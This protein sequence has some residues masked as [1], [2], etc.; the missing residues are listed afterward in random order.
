MRQHVVR[1]QKVN[2]IPGWDCHGLP[3]EL[4]ATTAIK[5]NNIARIK[6]QDP[7]SIRNRCKYQLKATLNRYTVL[8]VYIIFFLQSSRFCLKC[9]ATTKRRISVMGYYKRLVKGGKYLFDNASGIFNK[10][11]EFVH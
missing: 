9:N 5:N 1:G 8:A 11:T 7:I 2:Y 10:S 3:I 4:K 6:D